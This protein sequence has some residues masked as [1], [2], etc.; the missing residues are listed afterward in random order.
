M[1]TGSLSGQSESYDPDRIF[2]V[3]ELKQDLEVLQKHLEAIHPGLFNYMSV[4]RWKEILEEKRNRID[5]PMTELDFYKIIGNLL[6][7]IGDVHTDIEPSDAYYRS[8][9]Q[10]MKVF[11]LSVKWFN[12]H[13]YVIHNFSDDRS[14]NPGDRLM[15]I[16]GNSADSI[17]RIIRSYVPRDGFN[18]TSPDYVLGGIWGGYRNLYSILFGNPDVYELELEGSRE[19]IFKTKI[20]AKTYPQLFAQYQGLPKQKEKL[21]IDIRDK[22]A[23]MQVRSFHPGA[24]RDGGQNFRRFFKRAFVKIDKKGIE[25]LVLDLRNN[26]GGH[27]SVFLEL[28]SF[29]LDTPFQ[30]YDRLY[31]ITDSIPNHAYYLE[32]DQLKN[33]ETEIRKNAKREGALFCLQGEEG[34]TPVT[35]KEPN[36]D[37]KLFILVDGSCSSATGDFTGLMKNQHAATFVGDEVGGNPVTNC[38]GTTLTLVLPNSRIQA[39]IPTTRYDLKVDLPNNGHGIIPDI[40]IKPTIEQYI[41]GE[42]PVLEKIDQIDFR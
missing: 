37:G 13:L 41:S 21:S 9:N 11:P 32:R 28:A 20:K 15:R 42:D 34:T 5:S 1:L 19:E 23:I 26:G 14:I 4:E 10:V 8:L 35:P 18:L 31:T 7:S 33:M 16:N 2:S 6:E 3:V 27:Q 22:I 29:L 36:F 24:I 39:Y 12:D 40:L 17:Y 25:N 30:V 38:A